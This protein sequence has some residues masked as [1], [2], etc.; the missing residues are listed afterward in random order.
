MDVGSYVEVLLWPL[1][2]ILVILHGPLVEAALVHIVA[3]GIFLLHCI[4]LYPI[5]L[6]SVLILLFCSI[7]CYARRT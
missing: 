6:Y 2:Q 4:L 7:I 3:Y 5:L 1:L